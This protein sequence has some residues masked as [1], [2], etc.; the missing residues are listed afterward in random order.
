MLFEIKKTR[1]KS[2]WNEI[3]GDVHG[4]ECLKLWSGISGI[5]IHCVQWTTFAF[6]SSATFWTL[7]SAVLAGLIAKIIKPK[8][9]ME[10]FWIYI[11]DNVIVELKKKRAKETKLSQ[12]K[13]SFTF[14]EMPSSWEM[15]TLD[16]ILCFVFFVFVV[17]RD[18]KRNNNW[19]QFRFSESSTLACFRATN[20]KSE[21][22]R[23]WKTHE[24]FWSH[25]FNYVLVGWCM[26][27]VLKAFFMVMTENRGF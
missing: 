12:Q 21:T 19:Y 3:L 27:C 8:K 11:L 18:R 4:D 9:A 20:K 16:S 25:H 17:G 13:I 2:E 10:K 7:K 14:N 1:L 24:S 15:L 23:E 22:E 5:F 26:F 6:A